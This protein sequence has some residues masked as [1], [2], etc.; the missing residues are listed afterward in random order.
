MRIR[1]SD[2]NATRGLVRFLRGREYLAV[3]H[4]EGIVEAVPINSINLRAD[5]TRTMKDLKEWQAEHSDI[6]ATVLDTNQV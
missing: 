2:P 5:R 4:P 3:A 1:L 6:E